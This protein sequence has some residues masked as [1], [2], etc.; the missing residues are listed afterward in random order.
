MRLG[1]P[2]WTRVRKRSAPAGPRGTAQSSGTPSRRRSCAPVVVRRNTGMPVAACRC[3]RDGRHQAETGRP[4]RTREGKCASAARD[5]GRRA[6][7]A[8]PSARPLGQPLQHVFGR[9]G[10]GVFGALGSPLGDEPDQPV[11]T[12]ARLTTS[13][14][15]SNACDTACSGEARAEAMQA[16]RSAPTRTWLRFACAAQPASAAAG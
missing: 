4:H 2:A 8:H 10:S 11:A 5:C 15:S 13:P 1:R 9:R 12:P 7:T 3:Y 14:R 6:S 16:Q